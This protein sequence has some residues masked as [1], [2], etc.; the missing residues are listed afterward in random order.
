M[1][2]VGGP[3]P[4]TASSG[5]IEIDAS[6]SIDAS[7]RLETKIKP[8][9]PH[10]ISIMFLPKNS[11]YLPPRPRSS[12]AFVF[13]EVSLRAGTRR[14]TDPQEGQKEF[15]SHSAILGSLCHPKEPGSN[16]VLK[17]SLCQGLTAMS[18]TCQY[19]RTTQ[20]LSRRTSSISNQE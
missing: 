13:T 4:W 12:Q 9:V 1:S 16:Q 15:S 19:S 3:F 8:N 6:R 10:Q 17:N 5:T 7:F 18:A 11:D 2:M 14:H 20:P